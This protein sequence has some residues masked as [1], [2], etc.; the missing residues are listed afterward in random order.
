[1]QAPN[2]NLDPPL[3][4]AKL[5]SINTIDFKKMDQVLHDD[6]KLSS[7]AAGREM[8]LLC[9]HLLIVNYYYELVFTNTS[10]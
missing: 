10:Y 1:M 5:K 3:A 7:V 4:P 2:S 8:E 9:S 6:H